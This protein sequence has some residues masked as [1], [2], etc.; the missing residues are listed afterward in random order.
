MSV[1]LVAGKPAH[2]WLGLL[3]LLMVAFQVGTGKRWIKVPFTYHRKNGW[4]MAAAA[5]LHAF[6]GLGIWFFD[7]RIG[8]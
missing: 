4:A 8:P 6:W 5:V 3:L 7:F 2:L 1:P